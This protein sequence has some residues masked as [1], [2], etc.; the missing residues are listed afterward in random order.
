MSRL[1]D[2]EPGLE[3]GPNFLQYDALFGPEAPT[4]EPMRPSAQMQL[5]DSLQDDR[6]RSRATRSG[7][8]HSR[9]KVDQ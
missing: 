7:P 8:K 5:P 4:L 1:L 2:R 9:R 3:A 6:R